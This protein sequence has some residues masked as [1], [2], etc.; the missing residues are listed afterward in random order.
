MTNK[1]IFH[2]L[3][4]RNLKDNEWERTVEVS[5][6]ALN[7]LNSVHLKRNAPFMLSE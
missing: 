1:F 6:D 2:S 5:D 7:Q 3:K 4:E